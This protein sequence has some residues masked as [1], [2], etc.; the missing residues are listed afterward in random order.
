MTLVGLVRNSLSDQLLLIL[1][2]F[3]L[4]GF[5]AALLWLRWLLPGE[6]MLVAALLLG[7]TRQGV[8]G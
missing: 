8:Q 2:A 4:G 5:G 7:M 6:W 1:T 3:V